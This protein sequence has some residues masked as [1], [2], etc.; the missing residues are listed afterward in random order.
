MSRAASA[1]VGAEGRS[2]SGNPARS[3]PVGYFAQSEL[4]LPSL[5][6]LLPLLV[7]Y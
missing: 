4:P 5:A 3:L 7:L 6:L 2:T 1:R